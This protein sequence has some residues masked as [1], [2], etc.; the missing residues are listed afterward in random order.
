MVTFTG[1]GYYLELYEQVKDDFKIVSSSGVR[2]KIIISLTEGTTKLKDL[3]EGLNIDSSTILHAMKKLKNRD[4]IYKKN[5]EYFISQTGKVVGLKLIDMI[6]MLFTFKENE[7]LMFDSE[8]PIDMLMEFKDLHFAD[9]QLTESPD[10]NFANHFQEYIIESDNIRGVAPIANI[11]IMET[12]KL[13]VEHGKDL[14]VIINQPVFNETMDVLGS[15]ILD[16]MLDLISEDK[17]KIW[18]I[19]QKLNIS[20]FLTDNFIFLGFLKTSGNEINLKD[21]VSYHQ[22]AINWG[23]RLFDYYLKNSNQLEL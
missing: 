12:C 9:F 17:I 19:E 4:L 20:F 10:F 23:N 16:K 7:D 3:K 13:I 18:S 14:E 6:K 8:I 1:P 21:M 2:T 5:D 22:S 11:N 15:N